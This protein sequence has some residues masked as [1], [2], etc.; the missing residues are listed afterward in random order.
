MQMLFQICNIRK[1]SY[2]KKD[3][4]INVQHMRQ[5][6]G[7]TEAMKKTKGVDKMA[8]RYRAKSR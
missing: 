4:C 5:A 2:V 7:V 8:D 1:K 3:I 6:D